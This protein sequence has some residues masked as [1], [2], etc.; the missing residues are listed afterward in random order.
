MPHLPRENRA[1]T[2]ENR[3]L[4]EDGF[5]LVEN[6]GRVL[7]DHARALSAGDRVMRHERLIPRHSLGGKRSAAMLSFSPNGN[8]IAIPV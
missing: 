8:A 7:I 4:I 3:E 6:L 5:L 1:K 2:R